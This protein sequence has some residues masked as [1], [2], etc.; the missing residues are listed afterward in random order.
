MYGDG[1]SQKLLQDF[2]RHFEEDF[3]TKGG[4]CIPIKSAITGFT[5]PGLCGIMGDC[6]NALFCS[7]FMPTL[8]KRMW[9]ITREENVRFDED[10]KVEIINLKGADFIDGGNYEKNFRGPLGVFAP[11]AAEWGDKKIAKACIKR[12]DEE[13]APVEVNPK[14]G[15]FRN[16][17][18]G[19]TTGGML[20]R[21]RFMEGG[22]W[23]NLVRHG[24]PKSALSGPILD[25]APYPQ[26]LVAK[27][28][29]HTS[30]DLELVLYNGREE[31]VFELGLARLKPGATYTGLPGKPFTVDGSGK[32]TIQVSLQGRTRIH[33][34]PVVA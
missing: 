3:F 15:S 23:A 2:Y 31:G 1:R 21:A 12:I 17:G 34:E 4:S 33:L 29:S 9:L 22:D 16:K 8:A 18:M 5:I 14:T 25:S 24:P 32:A 26:V 13:F 6:S 27:A 11:T 30:K 28:F 19:T 7:P 10:G 20:T